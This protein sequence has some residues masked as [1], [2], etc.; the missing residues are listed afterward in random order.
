MGHHL[1][2]FIDIL[3]RCF[4]QTQDFIRNDSSFY[5]RYG[6]LLSLSSCQTAIC[7]YSD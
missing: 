7:I 6:F 1:L 5:V 4:V 3:W 2:E